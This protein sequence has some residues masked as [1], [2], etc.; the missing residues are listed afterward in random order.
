MGL[1]QSVVQHWR[2]LNEADWFS[3]CREFLTA[4]PVPGIFL[5]ELGSVYFPVFEPSVYFSSQ[6]NDA[7]DQK[8]DKLNIIFRN[9]VVVSDMLRFAS[10]GMLHLTFAG[11]IC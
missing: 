7:F 11:T 8:I 10:L 6:C 9:Y 3:L 5:T 2:G 1:L 4:E